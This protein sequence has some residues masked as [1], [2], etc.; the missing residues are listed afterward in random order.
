MTRAIGYKVCSISEVP[1]FVTFLL[2]KCFVFRQRQYAI[3]H[4]FGPV[5]QPLKRR[6]FR[7]NEEVVVGVREFCDCMN[8][9]ST[10]TEFLDLFE[11]GINVSLWLGIIV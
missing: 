8:P 11:D 9:V 6:R 3:A 4:W 2:I 10:T 7:S 1:H 5:T